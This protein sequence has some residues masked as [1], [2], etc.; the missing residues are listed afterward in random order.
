MYSVAQAKFHSDLYTQKCQ[1]GRKSYMKKIVVVTMLD[2]I[3]VSDL[4]SKHFIN[5][6]I[7][8]R[9]HLPFWL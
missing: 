3:L 2:S 9:K 5:R 4:L 7:P 6:L 1:I 8:S